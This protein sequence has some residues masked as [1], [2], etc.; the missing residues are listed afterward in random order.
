MGMLTS[1]YL[2]VYAINMLYFFMTAFIYS[3]RVVSLRV[4][5][6]PTDGEGRKAKIHYAAKMR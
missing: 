3:Y 4:I 2:S 6:W 5:S 1:R